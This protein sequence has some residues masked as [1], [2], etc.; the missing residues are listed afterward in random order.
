[1]P[2]EAQENLQFL[3]L[4]RHNGSVFILNVYS[5][6]AQTFASFTLIY[7]H[8]LHLRL[9]CT[10]PDVP[11]KFHHI[12]A[13]RV[14]CP[15]SR[16]THAK[17]CWASTVCV[18]MFAWE[19]GGWGPGL[20]TKLISVIRTHSRCWVDEGVVNMGYGGFTHSSMWCSLNLAICAAL[21]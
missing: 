1:M 17:L 6:S 9:F 20:Q 7:T 13:G 14:T 16:G 8:T 21:L 11:S 5:N 3:Y 12:K 10:C 2:P 15:T 18:G 4:F 19:H